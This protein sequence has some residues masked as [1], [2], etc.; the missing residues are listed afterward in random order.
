MSRHFL[1][2]FNFRFVRVSFPFGISDYQTVCI[3]QCRF[4]CLIYPETNILP[5]LVESTH[6]TTTIDRGFKEGRLTKDPV[7]IKLWCRAAT[8]K[9][10]INAVFTSAIGE[11]TPNWDVLLSKILSVVWCAALSCRPGDILNSS[12]ANKIPY[13]AWKDIDLRLVGANISG[14]TASVTIRNEKAHKYG[15]V[16]CLST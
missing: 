7:R 1:P 11:G 15:C 5:A 2:A 10:L 14:F 8:L 9:V 6:I 13:L 16:L 4:G 3:C 12:S